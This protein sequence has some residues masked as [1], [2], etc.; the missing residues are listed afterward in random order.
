MDMRKSALFSGLAHLLVIVVMLLGLP[1]LLQKDLTPPPPIPIEV[2]NISDITQAKANKVKPKDNGPKPVE[3]EKPKPKPKPQPPKPEEKVEEKKPD[4]EPEPAP[5]PEPVEDL[6]AEVIEKVDQEKPKEEKKKEKPK[7]T[8]KDKKKD[9][10]KKQKDFMALLNNLED[11]EESEASPAQKEVDEAATEDQAAENINDILSVTEL[12]L[13]KRQMKQCWNVPSGAKG[14]EDMIVEVHIEMNPDAT[15]KSA[16]LV[17]MKRYNSDP[18]F[19]AVADSALRATRN[20]KCDPLK[21]PL[22]RYNK[23]KSFNFSFNPKD[24]F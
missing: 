24:M 20:P 11:L 23:L 10:P 2:I 22:D 21:L 19:R 9:K 16:K 13:L 18:H 1:R 3:P 7:E 17:D 15:V 4:P 12:D 6:L 14:V 8:K 5:E